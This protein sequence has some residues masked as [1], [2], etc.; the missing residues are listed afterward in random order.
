MLKCRR[1]QRRTTWRVCNRKRQSTPTR[2]K[3]HSKM[4]KKQ[5]DLNRSVNSTKK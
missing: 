4:L 3:T 2:T 1:G 5:K